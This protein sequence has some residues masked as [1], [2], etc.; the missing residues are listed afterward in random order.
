MGSPRRRAQLESKAR[1]TL[2]AYLDQFPLSAADKADTLKGPYP[3]SYHVF[4][5]QPVPASEP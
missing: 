3:D 5:Y 2:V 4:K 1:L